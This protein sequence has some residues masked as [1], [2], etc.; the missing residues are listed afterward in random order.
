MLFDD[1]FKVHDPMWGAKSAELDIA[2]GQAEFDPAPGTPTLRWNRGFVFGDLDA[3][4][5]VRLAK[6][7][8][9]P[10]TSY[11]GVDLLGGGQPQLLSGGDRA[12]RL[13]HRGAHRRRQGRRQAPGGMEEGAGDQIPAPRRR[14]FCASRRRAR[15]VQIAI[16]G[17]P[18]ASFTAEPPHT[19]SYIGMLAA[20]AASKNGDT[21]VISDFKVTAPQ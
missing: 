9:D 17:K 11:A 1:E 3:C 2:N 13:F 5:S 14:T 8:T 21:W 4:A 20:S 18:A 10:T 7:T 16:N 15:D 19:P 12:Q 6:A